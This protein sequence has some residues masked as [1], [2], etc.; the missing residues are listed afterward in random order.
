MLTG[1]CAL[2][3]HGLVNQ[4]QA[5][6]LERNLHLVSDF[7]QHVKWLRDGRVSSLKKVLGAPERL[8]C[9]TPPAIAITFDD[10]YASNLVAAEILAEASLPWT[11]FISTGAVGKHR[12][13]WTA[14]LSLLI[15]HGEG[16]R[17]EALGRS[18][19]LQTREQRESAFQAIRY[20]MKAMPSELRRKTLDAIRARFPERETERVLERFPSLQMLT[21]EQVRQLAAA[22][23]EIGSHG[24]DHELHHAN[25]DAS[26]R[27]RELIESKKEIERQLGKPCRFF[28]FPNGDTCEHSAHEVEA[29]G[30]ELA[31]TTRP[32]F[33]QP[34]MNRCLLPR[35]TPSGSVIKLRQQ[36][37]G[38]RSSG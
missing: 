5:N 1:S 34:G 9:A 31:F 17:L 15:L 25:Q 2:C 12:T 11:L 36:L 29:A 33:I 16:N 37:S 35:V 38:L 21:W 6:R 19:S 22:G 7:R 27:R 4:R 13:I 23:V 28:A 14:E 24:V 26:V 20:P 8:G 3:Y 18:W 10:G 32:G 30:Y